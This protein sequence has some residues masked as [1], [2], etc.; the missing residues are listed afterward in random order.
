MEK[1]CMPSGGRNQSIFLDFEQ[2]SMKGCPV[3]VKGEGGGRGTSSWGE[4]G[5]WSHRGTAQADCSKKEGGQGENFG[6][7]REKAF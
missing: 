6:K 2:E 4:G 3:R 1:T 7:R 5:G